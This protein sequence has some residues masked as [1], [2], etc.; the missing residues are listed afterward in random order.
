M[1]LCATKNAN[2]ISKEVLR[3]S[4]PSTIELVNILKPKRILLL[5]G[6]KAFQLIQPVSNELKGGEVI[7][8]RIKYGPLSGIPTL[9]VPHPSA[10]YKGQ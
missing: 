6:N 5:S 9:G 3:R 10:I 2:E 8:E 1:S 7:N 4:L